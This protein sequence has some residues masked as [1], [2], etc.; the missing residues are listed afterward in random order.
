MTERVK[1]S[2]LQ[3]ALDDLSYP[4]MRDE[5]AASLS[6][7]TLL[8]ADGESN[9]GALVSETGPDSFEDSEDLFVELQS[10]LPIE[11]VGEPH[12]SEGDA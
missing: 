11:A 7:V 2:H 4:V 10:V 1:L 5:A 8:Y 12:Q 9:L 3:S 6:D